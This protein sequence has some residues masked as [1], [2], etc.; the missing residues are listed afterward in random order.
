M[1]LSIHC[2]LK[3]STFLAMSEHAGGSPDAPEVTDPVPDE[4]G[5]LDLV[6]SEN[7]NAIEEVQ[8]ETRPQTVAEGMATETGPTFLTSGEIMY[9]VE[10]R[11]GHPSDQ[12]QDNADVEQR[13]GSPS[14]QTQVSDRSVVVN[15]TASGEWT[16]QIKYNHC[17]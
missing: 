14:N 4:H 12:S 15:S 2:Q 17:F 10:E 13:G 16:F 9:D 8:S 6:M 7:N 3:T 5:Q 11:E 1:I